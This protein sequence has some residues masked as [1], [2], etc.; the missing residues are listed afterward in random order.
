MTEVTVLP[1]PTV[2]DVVWTIVVAAGT[3][4]R[5]G[6]RK[7][8]ERLGSRRVLDWSVDAA[9]AASDGVVVV[10]PPD[11][12][13]ADAVH[14][15]FVPGGSTRSESVRAGLAAVPDDA[16]VIVVHDAA[17]PFASSELFTAVLRAIGN[18][19]DAAVP[20]IAVTDTIKQITADGTV[21]TT[22][23]RAS[24]VAVQTPQAFRASALRRAHA[25]GA[26]G[27]D[28]AALVEAQGGWVVVVAGDE[29][30][31]KLT[32]PEDLV[33]ARSQIEVPS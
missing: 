21:I 32:R 1:S 33:W 11:E 25:V 23:P 26:E 5:F 28:D 13:E 15:R 29:R 30:N 7:Q 17:R 27:T 9:R 16:T 2:P 3:G 12:H 14:G 18:G 20:G 10:G 6:G 31:R 8:F 4:A 19:A 24:L 22:P